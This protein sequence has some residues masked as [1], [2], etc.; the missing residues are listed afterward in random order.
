MFGNI[1]LLLN[2]VAVFLL[3]G[4]PDGVA[5][6]ALVNLLA[7]WRLGSWVARYR[8]GGLSGGLTL[9]MIVTSNNGA[10]EVAHWVT[11]VV[12]TAFFVSALGPV[13]LVVVVVLV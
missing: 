7:Q 9:P 13:A 8:Y 10:F 11:A 6:A 1:L 12:G 3:W 5:V 4:Q 2:V